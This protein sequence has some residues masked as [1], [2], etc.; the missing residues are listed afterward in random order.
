MGAAFTVGGITFHLYGFLVGLALV[1]GW[2]LVNYRH[3]R[4]LHYTVHYK[5]KQSIAE[6]VSVHARWLVLMVAVGSLLGARLWH[7]FTDWNLYQDSWATNPITLIAIWQGGLSIIGAAIGGVL[8]LIAT[9]IFVTHNKW[10]QVS[11]Y[12][13]DLLIF[14]LPISQAIGRFGNW[15]NQELYGLPTNLPWKLYIEP[16]ARFTQYQD[17]A[18]YHPLFAYEALLTGAFG[19]TIWLWF[20]WRSRSKKNWPQLGSGFIAL[21]YL[22][23]YSWIRFGLDFLRIDKVVIGDAVLG[24]NQ[25]L[26]LLVAIM[27]SVVLGLVLIKKLQKKMVKNWIFISNILI[28]I[29]LVVVIAISSWQWAARPLAIPLDPDEIVWVLDA[30]AFSWY[31]SGDWTAFQQLKPFERLVWWERQYRV[32][33]QPQ[34]GKYILGGMLEAVG[35]QPWLMSTKNEWYKQ[36]RW[37][38]LPGGLIPEISSQLGTELVDAITF[39]RY[40]NVVVSLVSFSILA[41]A[42]GRYLRSQ[43]AG[44]LF[45]ILVTNQ[46]TIWHY[47]RLALVNP[48]SMLFQGLAV[49]TMVI[50]IEKILRIQLQTKTPKE[51][52][53]RTIQSVAGGISAGALVAA[54][55]SVKLDGVFLALGPLMMYFWLL[56]KSVRS[57]LLQYQFRQSQ[58]KQYQ[59]Q[60]V[61]LLHYSYWILAFVLGMATIFF[62]LEPE[63][64]ANPIFG[65]EQLIGSRLAQQ[66]RF[67]MAFEHLS[68]LA[69]AEKI[70]AACFDL[71]SWWGVATIALLEIVSEW[72]E[73][74]SG[75]ELSH[76]QDQKYAILWLIVCPVLIGSLFYGRTGF[77]R[78]VIPGVITLYILFLCVV[79]KLVRNYTKLN[80]TK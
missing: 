36:F 11:G 44:A 64:W 29:C 70:I 3:Y 54:A 61:V 17:V 28:K 73:K 62:V 55:S 33:D 75:K 14:G 80:E 69:I 51:H 38:V 40:T 2:Q 60:E 25:Q 39:I 15:V 34:L 37:R 71:R 79:T 74:W 20:W 57:F 1:L 6:V 59:R 4:E 22:W 65:L 32:I 56:A 52:I 18:F 35:Q 30:E 53:S 77:D 42:L 31:L 7:L 41:I 8:S 19:V 45:F 21:L 16:N 63:L 58:L 78:Y 24:V 5:K 12:I 48:Y 23:F 67:Y 9:A 10:R 27:S 50:S 49:I 13:L 76:W 68:V 72:R 46:T 66:Q 47:Y 26:L 43:F